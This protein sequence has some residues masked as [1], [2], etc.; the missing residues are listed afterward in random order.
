VA[1]LLT[2]AAACILFALSERHPELRH[3]LCGAKKWRSIALHA[4]ATTP[5]PTQ[6][7]ATKE[8]LLAAAVDADPANLLA[9]VALVQ[10]RY[11]KTYKLP[12]QHKLIKE[13]DKRWAAIEQQ[14]P[15]DGDPNREVAVPDPGYGALQLRLLFSRAAVRLNVQLLEEADGQD[16]QT[17]WTDAYRVSRWLVLAR[18]RQDPSLVMTADADPMAASAAAITRAEERLAEMFHPPCRHRA[19]SRPCPSSW[20]PPGRRRCIP[21]RPTT[22][23]ELARICSTPSI[24]DRQRLGMLGNA[25]WRAVRRV[26]DTGLHARGW[27]RTQALAFALAHTPLPESFM[28]AEIDRYIAAPGQALGYLVGQRELL[29]L[30]A[31]ARARL[32]PPL[33]CATS[34][35]PCWTTAAW[36]FPCCRRWSRPG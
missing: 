30:R 16:V 5:S 17:V 15:P 9:Q 29:R 1:E 21:R 23:A 6:D 20:P 25:A 3:G 19:R 11:R 26:V 8:Q 14:V 27:S 24:P 22:A 12:D 34:M 32:V 2:V 36:R 33:T 31:H 4:I 18:L 35:P 10:T 28:A 7:E 13:L